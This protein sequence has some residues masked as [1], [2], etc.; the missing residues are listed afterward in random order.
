MEDV[1]GTPEKVEQARSDR[2]YWAAPVERLRVTE[3]ASGGTGLNVDGRRVVGPLQGFGQL[4]QKT[5]RVRLTGAQVT[6]TEVVRVWKENFTQFWPSGN[7]FYAPLTGIKPGEVAALRLAM[8][9]GL[10]LSTGMMVIYSDDESFTLMTPQ[11]HMESGWITFSAYTEEGATVA[12]VQSI[13]RANDPAYEIGFMLF[14][15]RQQEQFWHAT[16]RALAKHFGVDADVT[17]QKTCVDPR[18]QWSQAPNVWLNAAVR[19]TLYLV[20][21][22]LRWAGSTVRRPSR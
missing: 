9:G 20:A 14:A 8:P 17:M 6:P 13:A 15:H 7:R 1:E 19:T 4:W 2:E 22:P 3:L 12:Q 21:A 10:P 18:R 11:G 5:Y 16:L